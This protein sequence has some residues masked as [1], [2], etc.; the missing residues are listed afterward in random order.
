MQAGGRVYVFILGAFPEMVDREV[1]SKQ[2]EV[3]LDTLLGVLKSRM[4]Y[5]RRAVPQKEGAQ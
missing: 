1:I 4:M 5:M 3:L 2:K